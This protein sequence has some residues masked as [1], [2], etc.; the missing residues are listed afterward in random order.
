MIQIISRTGGNKVPVREMTVSERLVYSPNTF[1]V[2][3]AC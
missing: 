2:V 1:G 3:S